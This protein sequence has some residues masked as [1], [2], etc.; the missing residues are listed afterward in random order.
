MKTAL[1]IVAFIL[2]FLI[3]GFALDVVDHGIHLLFGSILPLAIGGTAT[4]G[5]TRIH[6]RKAIHQHNLHKEIGS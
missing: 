1:F 4:Y 2:V 6:Y 5:Y 3:G